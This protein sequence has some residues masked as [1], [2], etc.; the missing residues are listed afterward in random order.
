MK[1]L[2]FLFALGLS[3]VLVAPPAFG[4]AKQVTYEE[5]T[6]LA[7]FNQTRLSQR[8]G[9]WADLHIRL[10][11]NFV[12]ERALSIAR[13]G[14]TYYLSDQTRLTAGYAYISRQQRAPDLEVP[15]HRPW[16]QIQ[17]IEKKR[18]YTWMQWIRLEERFRQ[19][20][21]G[22]ALADSYRFNW[23]FR[24]NVAMTIPLKGTTVDAGVPFVLVNNELHINA[25]R[26]IVN[27]YFDQNRLFVGLGYQ[28]AKHA[29]VHLGYL[30]V[31]Q[32][33][34][35][36]NRYLHIDAIRLFVMQNLDFR[37]TH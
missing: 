32:Q 4:Q 29:H 30:Y 2:C 20:T 27:N 1:P 8:S 19:D 11:E 34:P 7:Y 14:Y 24:Y 9:L 33:L 17:W 22:D 37:T 25:G 15:E 21:D 31:F 28:F 36:G 5:Q 10:T 3:C 16:Q 35:Q 18:W 23:R 6:W 26:E 13:V 12:D